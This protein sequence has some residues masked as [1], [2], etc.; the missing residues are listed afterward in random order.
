[1][2]LSSVR[3]MAMLHDRVSLRVPY[4]SQVRFDHGQSTRVC[5][6]AV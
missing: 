2:C 5:L 3:H 4:N 1:M 6:V